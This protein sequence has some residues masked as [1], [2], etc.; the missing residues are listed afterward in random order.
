M[1]HATLLPQLSPL[2]CAPLQFG[3]LP[4]SVYQVYT[5]TRAET[6]YAWEVG[7]RPSSAGLHLW[8]E[9]S[10]QSRAGVAHG[11][12]RPRM[13]ETE[14]QKGT[15]AVGN[16]GIPPLHSAQELN[17]RLNEGE[18]PKHVKHFDDQ[19]ETDIDYK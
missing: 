11:L 6:E 15:C 10:C 17:K 9:C 12:L 14:V 16:D 5:N 19:Y 8:Q 1:Q 4:D 3:I 13:T 18:P 2:T 7:G